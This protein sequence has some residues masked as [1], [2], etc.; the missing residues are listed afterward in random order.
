M[1]YAEDGETDAC[2]CQKVVDHLDTRT[3]AYSLRRCRSK[4]FVEGLPFVLHN[5]SIIVK[6]MS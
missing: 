5:E 1:G 4:V 3:K 2:C 6:G